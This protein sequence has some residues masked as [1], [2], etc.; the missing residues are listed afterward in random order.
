MAKDENKKAFSRKSFVNDVNE[1]ISNGSTKFESCERGTA[2]V[3][4]MKII[5][6]LAKYYLQTRI[7]NL[8]K[9]VDCS[10]EVQCIMST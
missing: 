9:A 4:Q 1:Y 7:Y 6:D 8:G 3:D 2:K 5:L 10:F